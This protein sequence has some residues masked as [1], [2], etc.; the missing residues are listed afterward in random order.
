MVQFLKT[1]YKIEP[2]MFLM[3]KQVCYVSH[4]HCGTIRVY[5]G[6][7][8]IYLYSNDISNASKLLEMIIYAETTTLWYTLDVSGTYTSI[9]EFR[10]NKS[11]GLV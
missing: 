6:P 8:P 11:C 3:I 1:I 10:I 4:I 2:N 5:I 7:S 9:V